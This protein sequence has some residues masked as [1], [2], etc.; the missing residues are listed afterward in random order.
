LQDLLKDRDRLRITETGDQITQS[1]S[2][3]I[4]ITAADLFEERGDGAPVVLRPEVFSGPQPGARI[5]FGKQREHPL[6][7][8]AVLVLLEPPLDRVHRDGLSL[9]V[10][11]GHAMVV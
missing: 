10:T 5:V 11:T 7:A 8:G 3:R 1:F 4:S 9:R 2:P 6:I